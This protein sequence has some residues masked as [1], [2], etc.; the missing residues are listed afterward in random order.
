MQRIGQRAPRRCAQ[1]ARRSGRQD[2]HPGGAEGDRRGDRGVAG[3]ATVH[4]RPVGDGDRR[5]YRRDGRAGEQ[6]RDGFA[7]R[8][9][10]FRA[11]QHVRGDDVAGDCRILQAPVGELRL[12][13]CAQALGE[14][15]V[16]APAE[17]SQERAERRERE[18][19]RAAQGQPDPLEVGDAVCVGR[20]GEAGA[21]DRS[22]RGA[23]DQVG[24]DLRPGQRLEHADLYRAETAA[25]GQH[26]GRFPC[27]GLIHVSSPGLIFRRT[28]A[29]TP[30]G[31][32]RW[33]GSPD[34]ARPRLPRGVLRRG[35]SGP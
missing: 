15:Q 14:H 28:G 26:E 11:I 6:R 34:R 9:D 20:G 1:D 31:S 10:D 16:V 33:P 2:Q 7:C 13:E 30:A 5:K 29:L 27:S 21:V 25:A 3:D 8:Q 4:Q 19:V 24:R 22:H 12:D 35:S 18:D 17:Q 23:D 32:P